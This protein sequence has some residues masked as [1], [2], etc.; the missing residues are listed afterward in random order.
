MI[1]WYWLIPAVVI[2]ATAGILLVAILSA[3]G[4]E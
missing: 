3:N 2:G 4:N 1:P